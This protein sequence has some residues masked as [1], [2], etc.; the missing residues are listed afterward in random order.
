VRV[1]GELGAHRAEQELLEPAS[2]TGPHD[3]HLRVRVRGGAEESLSGQAAGGLDGY[4][5]RTGLV[6]EPVEYAAGFLLGFLPGQ[7]GQSLVALVA[8]SAPV[9]DG[10]LLNGYG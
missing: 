8:D 2:A 1:V 9:A 7:H 6:A 10:S 3:D 5:R 4:P